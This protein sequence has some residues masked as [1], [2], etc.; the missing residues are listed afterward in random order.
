[1]YILGVETS[2]DETSCAIL[3]NF[4]VLSSITISSLKEHKKYGG[5]V[6]EIASRYHIKNIDKVLDI[7][8]KEARIRLCDIGLIAV[9]Y[10]PGLIG[11]LA[12]GVSFAKALA[13]SLNRPFIGV[14]HLYAHLFAPFLNL[15]SR[16]DFPFLGVVVSG[17]HTKIYYVKDFDCIETVGQTLDDACGE[18]FDK[19]AR[20]FGIGYPGGPIIDRLFNKN[21]KSSFQFKCGK[22]NFNLSF[23]GLKTAVIYKKLELEKKHLLDKKTKI[24]LISSFQETVVCTL[25]NTIKEAASRYGVLKIVCGGGVFANS[26][27]RKSLRIKNKMVL[28]SP[29]EYA[30]DNA[31]T[32][33]GLGFYL[34]NNKGIRSYYNLEPKAE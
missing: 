9:T 1:M 16:I 31:A 17:G 14:N 28:L 7:A 8:I 33:A 2:C 32:V 3:K 21:Y 6:P 19:V 25:V 24:K 29:I 13:F 34:Y 22:K 27:L 11:A 23:S 4:N 26:Y 18:V 20:E 30:T 12:V 10:T 5:I 15:K